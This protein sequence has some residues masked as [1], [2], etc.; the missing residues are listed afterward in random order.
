M[1]FTLLEIKRKLAEQYDEITLL[2]LL[3]INS[4]DIVDAFYDRIED[5]YEYF[6]NEL[7]I[8]EDTY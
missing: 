3:N 2:E 1:T 5:K 7:S 4:F 8:D 6:N